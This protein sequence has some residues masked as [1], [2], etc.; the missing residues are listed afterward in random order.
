MYICPFPFERPPTSSHPTPLG[1]HREQTLGSFK[2]GAARAQ[3]VQR[4]S[5]GHTDGEQWDKV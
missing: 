2:T 4:L 3:G 5:R 1:C